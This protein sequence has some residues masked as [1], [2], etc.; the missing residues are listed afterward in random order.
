M[1]RRITDDSIDRQLLHRCR[2]VPGSFF[3]AGSISTHT[4][5]VWPMSS[6]IYADKS[7][8]NTPQPRSLDGADARRE[9]LRFTKF[10]FNRT[11]AAFGTAE[12]EL[13]WTNGEKFL[14]RAEWVASPYSDL[15]LASEA[16]LRAIAGF[17]QKEISFELVGVKAL[18]A[19]DA[20]VV[21]VS[22]LARREGGT[23]RLLGC[24]LA[25]EDSL[26]SAV[27]ATLQATNRILGTVARSET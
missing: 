21:I 2:T 25:D 5:T 26:R 22:V 19:F 13:E 24:H 11:P 10:S 20:N 3:V 12:V 18:R 4:R 9:R 7:E 17:A 16:T 6:S 1:D 27:L 23:H 15:R 8:S 14:G